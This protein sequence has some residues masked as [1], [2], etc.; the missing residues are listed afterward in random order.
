MKQTEYEDL[1]YLLKFS[2]SQAYIFKKFKLT[3]CPVFYTIQQGG[4]QLHCSPA[5]QGW[6]GNHT[7]GVHPGTQRYRTDACHSM[8]LKLNEEE[9]FPLIRFLFCVFQQIW[10]P[11]F[12]K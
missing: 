9:L 7:N 1:F 3:I 5:D 12:L 2:E 6:G 8:T 10:R 11:L 4:L